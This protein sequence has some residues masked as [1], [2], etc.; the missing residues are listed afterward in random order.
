MNEYLEYSRYWFS[1][2]LPLKSQDSAMAKKR[3]EHPFELS[4]WKEER[5]RLG[6]LRT[7]KAEPDI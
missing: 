2:C 3:M 5:K 7:Y 1:A 4:G 6:S